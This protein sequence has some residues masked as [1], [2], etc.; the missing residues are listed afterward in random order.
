MRFTI[1]DFILEFKIFFT[2]G[3]PSGSLKFEDFQNFTIQCYV[4]ITYN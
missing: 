1:S 4:G 3:L 2:I